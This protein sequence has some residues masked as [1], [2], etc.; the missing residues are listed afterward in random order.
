MVQIVLYRGGRWRL[1]TYC[2]IRIL[3]YWTVNG[4]KDVIT[5]KLLRSLVADNRSTYTYARQPQTHADTLLPLADTFASPSF[6][7]RAAPWHQKVN[8]KIPLFR[9]R[10]H[11]RHVP[12]GR[13]RKLPLGHDRVEQRPDAI[14]VG[15]V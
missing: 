11:Q 12:P 3:R 1:H 15:V 2:Q 8:D 5:Q 10:R 14:R 6:G 13:N 9:V 7:A 4:S